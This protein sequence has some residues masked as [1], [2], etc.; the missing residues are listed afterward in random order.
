MDKKLTLSLNQKII[1]RA[2]HYAKANGT[3]LSKMIESY[4]R[5][6]TKDDSNENEI[7]ITPLVE[8]LCGVGQLTEDF[9]LKTSRMKYLEDKHK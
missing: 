7:K 6:I 5:S 1:E 4:F 8:N 3:S 9:D 2:K